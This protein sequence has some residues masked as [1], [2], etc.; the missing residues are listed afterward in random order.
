M[1]PVLPAGLVDFMH[2]VIGPSTLGRGVS[3][4]E[5]SSGFEDRFTLESVASPSGLTHQLWNRN[6]HA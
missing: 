4:W 3:L 2:L 1:R 5:G 6:G